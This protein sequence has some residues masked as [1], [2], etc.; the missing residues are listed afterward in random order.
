[1]YYSDRIGDVYFAVWFVRIRDQKYTNNAFDGVVKVEKILV[2]DEQIKN[3]LETEEVDVITA[4]IINERNPV[5]YGVDKRWA[6]HLYPV[7]ITES[8]VK[9]KYLGES[10]FLNLF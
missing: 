4:N 6:N 2:T 8:Y 5:C 10:M 9:S 7:Y 3:G 1:M